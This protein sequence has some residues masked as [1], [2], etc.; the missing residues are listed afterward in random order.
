MNTTTFQS[1]LATHMNNFVKFKQL[2][3][4]DYT[5]QAKKLSHFDTF[6][7]QRHSQH[8]YLVQQSV[9]EYIEATSYLRP[10]S[11]FNRLSI[12][13]EFSRYL[14]LFE[15]D[16]YTLRIIPVKRPNLP[17]YYLYSH[18]DIAALLQQAKLLTPVNS[19]R[20][21]CFE[22]LI[23]LL[24]V[25][26]LRIEEALSLNIGEVMPKKNLLF[27]RQGKFAKDRYLVLAKSTSQAV[28]DYFN[29]QKSCGS[30]EEDDPFFITRSGRRLSYSNA[31]MIFRRLIKHCNI[32]HNAVHAPR[33]HDF[34]HTFATN[35]LI[36]WYE[37]GEDVNAKL[38]ILAT[39]MG[40]VNI[41]STQIYLHISSKLL[42]TAKNRF[43]Q[44][45][46]SENKKKG[47]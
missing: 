26:G 35:C 34:R 32:G 39:Y 24:Y 14:K 15:P 5:E 38:P 46:S 3:G 1:A 47:D 12:V 31:S 7:C 36:K 17:R 27:V 23:G 10:N 18:E 42:E 30:F 28:H 22:M 20:P 9:D 37:Q 43:H 40:H 16:S 25:T 6:L 29:L 11:Q 33:L 45:F 41:A 13:R 8:P 44:F 2:Q 4:F 21:A 19:I